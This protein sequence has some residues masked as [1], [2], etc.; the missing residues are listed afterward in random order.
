VQLL[1]QQLPAGPQQALQ[2][3]LCMWRQGG[4]YCC[5]RALMLLLHL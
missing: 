2:L 4:V 3:L 5:L 1:L